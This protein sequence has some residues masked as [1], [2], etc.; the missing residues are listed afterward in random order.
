MGKTVDLL[1]PDDMRGFLG[2]KLDVIF[3][4][5]RLALGTKYK[6]VMKLFGSSYNDTG[7]IRTHAQTHIYP[8]I[9]THLH[10]YIHI[11]IQPYTHAHIRA[12]VHIYIS[13]IIFIR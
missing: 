3:T 8:Y 5:P 11:Y 13:I 10:T 7:Y 9:H 1:S 4:K 2:L 12:C 6:K